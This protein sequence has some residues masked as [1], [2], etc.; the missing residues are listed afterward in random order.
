MLE[1]K[2]PV[3]A[4][5]PCSPPTAPPH[6][7]PLQESSRWLSDWEGDPE[8][9]ANAAPLLLPSCLWLPWVLVPSVNLISLSSTPVQTSA[10]PRFHWCRR[11]NSGG[12]S[13]Q[14]PCAVHHAGPHS[15]AVLCPGRELEWELAYWKVALARPLRLTYFHPHKRGFQ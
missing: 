5:A 1:E 13:V 2:S 15:K 8:D 11:G 6:V 12:L 4:A 3:S 10:L 9:I 14:Q 7:L